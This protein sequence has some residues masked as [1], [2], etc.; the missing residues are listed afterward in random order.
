MAAEASRTTEGIDQC[1]V[2]HFASFANSLGRRSGERNR[3]QP[4]QAVEPLVQGRLAAMLL[5]NLEN[6]LP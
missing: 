6:V 4:A 1:G 3:R 2:F 5:Q